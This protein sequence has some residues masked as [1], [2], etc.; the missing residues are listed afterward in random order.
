MLR[1]RPLLCLALLLALF[2]LSGLRLGI[3]LPSHPLSASHQP[4]QLPTLTSSSHALPSLRNAAILLL[5][6][7]R[8]HYLERT[9]ASLE[10]VESAGLLPVF[11]SQDGNHSATAAVARSHRVTLWQRPRIPMLKYQAGQAY[12]AQHYKVRRERASV[13]GS[14]A[15]LLTL[16]P[17]CPFASGRSIASS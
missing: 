1:T 14:H 15:K 2:C 11:V 16:R 8:P 7:N 17:S 9:L 4:T 12:L 3:H 5:C 13:P 6:Y 10:A